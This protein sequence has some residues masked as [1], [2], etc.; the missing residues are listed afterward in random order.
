MTI[1]HAVPRAADSRVA[2]VVLALQAL[3]TLVVMGL[4]DARLARRA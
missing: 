2:A 1:D 4:A 3:A